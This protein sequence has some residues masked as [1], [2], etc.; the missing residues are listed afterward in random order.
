MP[1]VGGSLLEHGVEPAAGDVLHDVEMPPLVLA[2]AEDRDDVGVVQPP[3]GLGL[4]AEPGEVAVLRQE[5]Q[6]H[7]AVERALIRLADDPHAAPADLAD[8]PELAPGLGRPG[9]LARARRPGGHGR[10]AGVGPSRDPPQLRDDRIGH[11]VELTGLLL[12]FGAD[13][14]MLGHGPRLGDGK[15]PQHEIGERVLARTVGAAHRRLVVPVS[16]SRILEHRGERRFGG[17]FWIPEDHDSRMG[18]GVHFSI[19]PSLARC[20]EGPIRDASLAE[21]T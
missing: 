16:P 1:G 12:A 6:R 15:F 19:I 7:V 14:E 20:D 3:G 9:H 17:V 2:H 10:V 5:L 18:N 13:V 21:R 8:D 11:P 4:A